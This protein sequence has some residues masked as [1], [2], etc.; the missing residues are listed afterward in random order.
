MF[1]EVK[2]RLIALCLS[3]TEVQ[4]QYH[5]PYL[6]QVTQNQISVL[7]FLTTQQLDSKRKKVKNCIDE[8][9]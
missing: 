7:S 5:F 6:K 8:D 2:K 9:E 4:W 1:T 3:A